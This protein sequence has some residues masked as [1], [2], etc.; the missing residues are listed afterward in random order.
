MTDQP[1]EQP[2]AEPYH[3]DRGF[4]HMDPVPSEYGGNVS[5]YQSSA[6][7]PAIWVSV[8]CPSDLNDP[9]SEPIAAVAHVTVENARILR[10]QL[11]Y[12]IGVSE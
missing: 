6:I 9:A 3:T 7:D 11:I 4:A 5:V 8:T 12:L 10:D 1:A 2:S